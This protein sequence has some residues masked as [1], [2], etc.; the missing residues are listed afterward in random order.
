MLDEVLF[1][2]ARADAAL[3]AARLVTVDVNR[4]A[5]YVAGVADGDSH[6]LVFNQIFELDFL[7][8]VDYLGAAVVAIGFH[9]FAQLGDDDAAKLFVAGQDFVQFLDTLA[10]FSQFLENFV[11]REAREA[12]QLEF[13]DGIDLGIGQAEGVACGDGAGGNAV[14]FGIELDAANVLLGIA[15]QHADGLVGEELEEV[16]A[17]VGA[18]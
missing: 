17:G 8:A 2:G 14:L 9:H 16:F 10:D 3:A 12:V 15:D 6:F 4:S 7:D 13:E 11:D 1:A 18:A 5:L